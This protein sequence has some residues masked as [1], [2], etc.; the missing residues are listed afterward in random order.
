LNKRGHFNVCC[1]SIKKIFLATPC[2]FLTR[3]LRQMNSWASIRRAYTKSRGRKRTTRPR[4]EANTFFVP[5]GDKSIVTYA[6]RRGTER[7][8]VVRALTQE[9][10][11]SVKYQVSRTGAVYRAWKFTDASGECFGKFRYQV[12]VEAKHNGPVVPG[13]SGLHAAFHPL[14]ALAYSGHLGQHK[15]LFQVALRGVEAVDSSA[16]VAKSITPEREVKG[17]EFKQLTSGIYKARGG[18]LYCFNNAEYEKSSPTGISKDM[19]EQA[20]KFD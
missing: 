11:E 12:G 6:L 19:F 16:L 18:F 20:L 2:V 5:T 4:S 17:E 1:S 15:R 7:T 9:E 13:Q 3:M 10:V 8:I 14:M